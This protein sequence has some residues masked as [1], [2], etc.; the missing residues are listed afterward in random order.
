VIARRAAIAERE[1]Q[2]RAAEDERRRAERDKREQRDRDADRREA[3]RSRRW[4]ALLTV[5]PILI[6]PTIISITVFDLP[7]RLGYGS[8]G[9]DR[10]EQLK[11]QLATKGCTVLDPIDSEYASGNVSRLV[12][13]EN[14]C[15]RVLAAGGGGH[16]TL[17]LRLYTSEGKE[18]GAS[19]ETTDPQ[20][21]YCPRAPDMMRYEIIVSAASKG[22]LSHAVLS[23]PPLSK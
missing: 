4:G 10:L 7:A 8:S 5:I 22:R 9:S 16:S 17:G 21:Q 19:S 15:I 2:A 18:V 20:L 6:A 11:T 23:C 13:V 12:H 1:R 3:R 14:Q